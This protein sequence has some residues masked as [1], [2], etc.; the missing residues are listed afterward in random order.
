MDGCVC[1]CVDDLIVSLYSVISLHVVFPLQVVGYDHPHTKHTQNTHP[2]T[3]THTHTHT[4]TCTPPHTQLTYR[5]PDSLLETAY[6]QVSK[7]LSEFT[8]QELFNVLWSLAKMR[9][10]PPYVVWFCML[11]VCSV[12]FCACR[13]VCTLYLHSMHVFHQ[14]HTSSS[15]Y[16]TPHPHPHPRT[17]HTQHHAP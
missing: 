10:H 16:V 1:V 11:C 9:I 8:A 3:S 6:T 14:P 4:H 17:T 7:Y 12:G 15:L 2:Y 13:I 5:L